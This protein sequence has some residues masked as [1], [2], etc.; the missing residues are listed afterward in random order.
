MS[1]LKMRKISTYTADVLF[2]TLKLYSKMSK[3]ERNGERQGMSV[4]IH[5]FGI[6]WKKKQLAVFDIAGIE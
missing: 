3:L 5:C 1:N 6:D 4:P 2:G